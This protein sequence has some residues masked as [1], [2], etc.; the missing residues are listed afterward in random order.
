MY[1]FAK[2]VTFMSVPLFIL[3]MNIMKNTQYYANK[4]GRDT[5]QSSSVNF[6]VGD[7]SI[8]SLKN[9]SSLNKTLDEEF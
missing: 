3:M 6:I 7:A 1:D 5:T 9:E 8:I 2:E 4:I